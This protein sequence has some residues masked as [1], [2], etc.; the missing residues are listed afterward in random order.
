[1]SRIRPSG[2]AVLAL[3]LVLFGKAAR[4]DI[5]VLGVT[6]PHSGL[7]FSN[8]GAMSKD[9]VATAL[10]KAAV[11]IELQKLEGDVLTAACTAVFELETDSGAPKEGQSLL[12]AFPVTGIGGEA[13]KIT[14]FEVMIDGVHERE[15]K[16][17]SIQLFSRPEAPTMFTRSGTALEQMKVDPDTIGFFGYKTQI[18]GDRDTDRYFEGYAWQQTFFP[19]RH[20]RIQIKYRMTL[21]AQSLAYAKKYL[22]SQSMDVVPFDAMWAGTSDEK[23]F[24]L[25]YILRSGATWK[26][27]IGHETVVLSAAK[28]SGVTFDTDSVVTLG[29]QRFAGYDQD[30]RESIMRV[31]AG[32]TAPGVGQGSGRVVWEIDHE[33]PQQDILV[34]IPA[35]AVQSDGKR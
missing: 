1:M 14:Q 6:G 9:A 27:P 31:Y 25:D 26:G 28:N 17:R 12:V 33:K 21:H 10:T 4:C 7:G 5:S 18:L 24:F 15:L 32:V 2:F 16:A 19:G 8:I 30:L 34:E 11:L 23:A 3:G 29:R 22:H 13:V 20:C 35:T